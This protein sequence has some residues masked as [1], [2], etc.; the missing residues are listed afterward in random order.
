MIC[1]L[2]IFSVLQNG[3]RFP[4]CEVSFSFLLNVRAMVFQGAMSQCPSYQPGQEQGSQGDTGHLTGEGER[5]RSVWDM[6]P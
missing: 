5:P 3:Q 6:C 1:C 2:L 4:F